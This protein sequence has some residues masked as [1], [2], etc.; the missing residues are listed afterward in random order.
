MYL[1]AKQ[2]GNIINLLIIIRHIMNA[3]NTAY[4]F[5]NNTIKCLYKDFAPST[6]MTQTA[7]NPVMQLTGIKGVGMAV[8]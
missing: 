2:L 1:N 3:N 5:I 4:N 8:S 6:F 7:N